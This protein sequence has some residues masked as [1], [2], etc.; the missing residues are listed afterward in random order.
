MTTYRFDK[1]DELAVDVALDF[2]LLDDVEG[3]PLRARAR[4]V[5]GQEGCKHVT[6]RG[7]GTG[8]TSFAGRGVSTWRRQGRRHVAGPGREGE[9]GV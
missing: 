2:A 5:V 8:A 4:K 3:V 7:A 9:E 6:E 1:L